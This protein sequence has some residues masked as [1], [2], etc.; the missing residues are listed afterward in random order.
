MEVTRLGFKSELQLPAYATPIAT[1]GPSLLY[2]YT[3]A[4]SNTRSLIHWV[5]PGTEPASSLILVGFV[6]AEPQWDSLHSLFL[7]QLV[8]VLT[9]T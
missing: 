2:D 1:R 3:T 8:Y 9:S 5:K 4:L 6:T 7:Y